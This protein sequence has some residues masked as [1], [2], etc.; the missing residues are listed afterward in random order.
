MEDKILQM[1]FDHE[2]WVKAID[3]GVGKDIN[4]AQ[5]IK[6]CTEDAR[7][8][9]AH[10]MKMGRYEITPPHTALIPKDLRV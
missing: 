8:R 2:R 9:M 6:L 10:A 1:F 4:R 7:I 3:K 5:L